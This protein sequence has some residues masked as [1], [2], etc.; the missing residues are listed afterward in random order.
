MAKQVYI[1]RAS[2]SIWACAAAH[3]ERILEKKEEHKYPD[4]LNLALTA[5]DE[6]MNHFDKWTVAEATEEARHRLDEEQQ[7]NAKANMSD[8][9]YHLWRHERD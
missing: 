3:I 4:A 8:H 2:L 5:L 1:S 9:L 6:A 7:D